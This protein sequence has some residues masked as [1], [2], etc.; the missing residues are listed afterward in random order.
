MSLYDS[1]VPVSMQVQRDGASYALHLLSSATGGSPPLTA[2]DSV[3]ATTTDPAVGVSVSPGDPTVT[4]DSVVTTSVRD[5][6]ASSPWV[7]TDGTFTAELPAPVEENT[8]WMWD[9][10]V[11]AT[12]GPPEDRY[13]VRL[14]PKMIV[15]KTHA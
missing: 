4:I 3:R 7:D 9:L 10:V 2:A 15:R 5:A 13:V 12:V 8:Q 6:P 1:Y 14:D 11:T